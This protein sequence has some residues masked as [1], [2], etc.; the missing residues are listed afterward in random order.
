MS[1]LTWKLLRSKKV[2]SHRSRIYVKKLNHFGTYRSV[3]Q[4]FNRNI[5]LS[6]VTNGQYWAAPREMALENNGPNYPRASQTIIVG[7]IFP[8]F[9]ALIAYWP[10]FLL[11]SQITGLCASSLRGWKR[12]RFPAEHNSERPTARVNKFVIDSLVKLFNINSP[13]HSN[14]SWNSH[15]VL[16][17]RVYQIYVTCSRRSLPISVMWLKLSVSV[18][19]ITLSTFY[20]N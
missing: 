10:S 1:N 16:Y 3:L 11:I 15:S 18:K 13:L 9:S 20:Q 5:S 17:M 12:L 4:F 2:T 6:V 14:S 19:K 7:N 8:S